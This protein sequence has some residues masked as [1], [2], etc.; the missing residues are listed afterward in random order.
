MSLQHNKMK[1]PGILIPV[2]LLSVL[3][4]SVF[5]FAHL[6]EVR[7]FGTAHS[8]VDTTSVRALEKRLAERAP[9]EKYLPLPDSRLLSLLPDQIPGFQ[10]KE[11][12]GGTFR[13]RQ[14][15]FAE[16]KKVFVNAQ[17]EMLTLSLSD[18]VGD[19]AALLHAYR[20]FETEKPSGELP[21]QQPAS[22]A[23]HLPG[24]FAFVREN[25][26]GSMHTLEAGISYRFLLVI[27]T[28]CDDERSLFQAALDQLDWQAI[29][30]VYEEGQATAP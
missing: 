6:S 7:S 13:V 3:L 21:L 9:D 24:C 11:T 14:R 28:N 19:T 22:A 5:A 29:S 16:A 18:C 27:N 26:G 4:V 20:R 8:P 23:P 25:A 30:E 1:S 12:G 2:S 10:L 15:T 17:Q